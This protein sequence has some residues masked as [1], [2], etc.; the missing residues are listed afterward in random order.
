MQHTLG[1]NMLHILRINAFHTKMVGAE[2]TSYKFVN[3]M[4]EAAILKYQ[5]EAQHPEL[6]F[7]FTLFLIDLDDKTINSVPIPQIKFQKD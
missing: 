7:D 6:V 3:N 1:Y 4:E 5:F 2:Q